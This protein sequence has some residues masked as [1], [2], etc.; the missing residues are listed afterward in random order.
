MNCQEIRIDRLQ[1]CLQP[2]FDIRISFQPR[3]CSKNSVYSGLYPCLSIRATFRAWLVDLHGLQR[4][5]GV[6]FHEM[7]I[8]HCVSHSIARIRVSSDSESNHRCL[9]VDDGAL[10]CYMTTE[11]HPI[12][13]GHDLDRQL[14]ERC[15]R[16]LE[17][18]L[19]EA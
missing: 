14:R 16:I 18:R 5:S 1:R 10:R 2:C 17:E 11:T 13:S 9:T 3:E 19:F 6:Q 4:F 15:L 8:N 12:R 7:D